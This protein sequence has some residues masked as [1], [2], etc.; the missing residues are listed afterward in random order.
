MNQHL[1]EAIQKNLGDFL[2]VDFKNQEQN[3]TRQ[4]RLVESRMIYFSICRKITKLSYQEIGRTIEPFKD[5]STVLYNVRKADDLAQYSKS[6]KSLYES[7]LLIATKAAKDLPKPESIEDFALEIER[8]KKMNSA[9][10]RIN[11]TQR[12]ELIDI[13]KE[14][15][16]HKIYH[17]NTGLR[18]NKIKL[19]QY[20]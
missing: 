11:I 4:R 7:S 1:I 13:K 19:F 14:I 5:H 3:S 10:W 17:K 2:M 12:D 9:L 6:F 8:L 16:K 18:V 20:L 15:K